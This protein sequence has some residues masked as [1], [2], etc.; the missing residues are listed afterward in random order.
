MRVSPGGTVAQDLLGGDCGEPEIIRLAL[1]RI[2]WPPDDPRWYNALKGPL[3]FW[4]Y[5]PWIESPR[6]QPRRSGYL[7]SFQLILARCHAN[8]RGTFGRTI[9]HDVMAMGF[10]DGASGW[11]TEDEALAFAVTL[12]DAGARTDVRDDLLKSTP[13]GWACRWGRAPIVK[14]LLRRGVD[15]IEPDAES[16]ATP[17]AWAEKMGHRE[18]VAMLDSICQTRQRVSR[19][20][21]P[22]RSPGPVAA[23]RSYDLRTPTL[24]VEPE[25]ACRAAGR[26]EIPAVASGSPK[27]CNEALEDRQRI[28][29]RAHA[30]LDA[31]RRGGEQELVAIQ[32]S[33]LFDGS[34]EIEVVEDADHPWPQAPTD[35]APRPAVTRTVRHRSG[36]RRR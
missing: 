35:G 33:C 31:E 12:L 34:L 19:G 11:I 4:S 16:W 36:R 13:L 3:S 28:E 23:N 24:L 18:I 20:A 8:V 21:R 32:P 9:L 10:H 6:W 1:A 27:A 29:R 15:P 5:V 7:E 30:F 14:E 25:R 2:D 22:S 17:R 26:S